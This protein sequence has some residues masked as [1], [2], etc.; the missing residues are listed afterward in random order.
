MEQQEAAGGSRHWKERPRARRQE[1]RGR[2]LHGVVKPLRNVYCPVGV[3]VGVGG[4]RAGGT[5]QPLWAEL[6][7]ATGRCVAFHSTGVSWTTA[8][9]PTHKSVDAHPLARPLCDLYTGPPGPQR[10]QCCRHCLAMCSWSPGAPPRLRSFIAPL[11]TLPTGLGGHVLI[12]HLVD[13]AVR[14]R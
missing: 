14:S 4:Q 9:G 11:Q 13:D 2:R 8:V 1:R 10:H 3:G 6:R 12:I 5:T 7:A